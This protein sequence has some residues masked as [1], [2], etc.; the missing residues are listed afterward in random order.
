MTRSRIVVRPLGKTAEFQ[1]CAR[2]QQE[3]WGSAGVSPELLQVTAKNG[4]AVIGAFSGNHLAGFLYAFLARRRGRLAHWSHLMAVEPGFRDRGLG[5]RMKT[6]HREIALAQGVRTIAW[7]YDPLQSR[8][9]ALNIHRLGAE[10]REYLPDCYGSFPSRIECGLPSD[11]FVAEWQIARSHV[12]RSMSDDRPAIPIDALPLANHVEWD[13]RAF[14]INRSVHLNLRERRLLVE[15]PADPDR[16]RGL[17]VDL[18]QRWRLETRRVF[19]NYFGKGY[20]V[21][22]FAAPPA[23]NPRRAF[24]LLERRRA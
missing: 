11:R 14:P 22:D 24:Y 6:A 15:I 7:T 21:T 5:L 18:A 9:A 4:G 19:Q 16:M 20:R 13:A 17:D 12:A 3:V 23:D 1:E 2:L 10:A 8:N